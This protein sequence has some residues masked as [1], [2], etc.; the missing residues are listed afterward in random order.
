MQDLLVPKTNI[1]IIVSCTPPSSLEDFGN[2]V[3][4]RWKNYKKILWQRGNHF[5][6][7]IL[8]PSGST[9]QFDPAIVLCRIIFFILL[10]RDRRTVA[11]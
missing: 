5:R 9:L 8:Y 4:A 6:I 11:D 1:I 10:F 3:V 7:T 2:G